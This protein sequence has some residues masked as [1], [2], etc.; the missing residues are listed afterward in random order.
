MRNCF[1]ATMRDVRAA[2]ATDPAINS[3]AVHRCFVPFAGCCPKVQ[4]S[5]VPTKG[6]FHSRDF[7]HIDVR[8]FLTEAKLVRNRVR[9]PGFRKTRHPVYSRRKWQDSVMQCYAV[10]R[11]QSRRTVLNPK[12]TGTWALI[13]IGIWEVQHVLASGPSFLFRCKL[14]PPRIGY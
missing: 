1:E 10:M 13:I 9:S 2:Q 4:Q 11:P 3:R 5:G 8:S 14:A 12:I 6:R 7:G